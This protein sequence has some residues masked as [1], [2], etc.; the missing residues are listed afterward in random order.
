MLSCG[1]SSSNWNHLSRPNCTHTLIDK[2]TALCK[3]IDC[4]DRR[5]SETLECIVDASDNLK[6]SFDQ[7]TCQILNKTATIIDKVK[8]HCDSINNNHVQ[9]NEKTDERNKT[10][11]KSITI[12]LNSNDKR[13]V[14]TNQKLPTNPNPNTRKTE[15][16]KS[17]N[18]NNR[19][20]TRD[21]CRR[22]PAGRNPDMQEHET[23]DL[24]C[25]PQ[26]K[27]TI[28]QSTLLVGSSIFKNIKVSELKKNTAVRSFP[29]ATVKTLQNKLKQFNLDKCE[30]III[31]VGGNDADQGIDLDNFSDNYSSLLNGLSAENRQI[32]VSG[33]LPRESVNLG[34]Y[35]GCLKTLS[36]AQ[37]VDFVDHYDGFL[38]ASG[39]LADSYFHRDKVHPNSFGIKK[40][41]RNIDAFHKVTGTGTHL[42]PS[43]PGRKRYSYPSHSNHSNDSKNRRSYHNGPQYCH[44]C[45]RKGHGTI[46]CWYNGRN[47]NQVGFRQR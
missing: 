41:L 32:I 37:V 11:E 38:F 4:N 14:Q 42:R 39:D 31:H 13:S 20:S 9:T 46:D 33:L 2:L 28:N 17:T 5:T 47:T 3:R 12:H 25:S 44:I 30:T 7:K 1:I 19:H 35:N 40:M 15:H 21:N 8:V 10:N 45:S 34:P 18:S 26:P 6:T 43:A 16:T 27:K 22:V 36:E 24:T 23:V 29:G